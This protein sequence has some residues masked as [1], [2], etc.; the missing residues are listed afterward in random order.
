MNRFSDVLIL[1]KLG[2][3]T[4]DIKKAVH[5]NVD[6]EQLR[7]SSIGHENYC[8]ITSDINTVDF[9]YGDSGNVAI[10][11]D[12]TTGVVSFPQGVG[13]GILPSLYTE[14]FTAD[15]ID[16]NFQLNYI[17]SGSTYKNVM[18]YVGGSLQP[19]DGVV[20]TYNDSL[21]VLTVAGTTIPEGII[22]ICAYGLGDSSLYGQNFVAT[23][24]DNIFALD[25][26]VIGGKLNNILVFHGSSLLI[27]TST[28]YTYNAS[29]DT[30]TVKG[31]TPGAVVVVFYNKL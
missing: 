23:G 8:D 10:S 31:T 16:N 2:I 30:I 5:I 21:K 25:G 20:Y 28:Y 7:L 13:G 26:K 4:S 14:H 11:I 19:P 3:E 18:V 29:N 27:P 22:V 1:A 6:D 17:K 24:G 15:G 12:H 9:T